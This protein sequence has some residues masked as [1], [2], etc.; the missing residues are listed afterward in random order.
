PDLILT[1]W[2]G[3]D[4][5]LAWSVVSSPRWVRIERGAVTVFAFVA[6]FLAAV[7]AAKAGP[8]VR[9]LGVLMAVSFLSCL[10]L[11]VVLRPMEPGALAA[12]LY[13]SFFRVLNLFRTWHQLPTW[14]GVM[15]LA[16]LREVLGAR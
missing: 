3:V 14:L 8:V 6:F 10:A 12:F 7:L 2:W 11:Q 13:V 15:N 16:V 5:L 1:V 9:V 4:V